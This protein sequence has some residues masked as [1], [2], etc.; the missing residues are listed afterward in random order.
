MGKLLLMKLQ[1]LSTIFPQ[2]AQDFLDCDI[3][4]GEFLGGLSLSKYLI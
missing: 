2:L 3:P 4:C 1:A